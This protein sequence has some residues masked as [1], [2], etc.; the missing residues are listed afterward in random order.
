MV[1]SFQG[2]G[3]ADPTNRRRFDATLSRACGGCPDPRLRG[4]DDSIESNTALTRAARER[5]FGGGGAGFVGAV[6]GR[7]EIGRAGFAGEEQPVVDRHGKPGAIVGMAG[8][9]L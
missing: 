1:C 3:S 7:E 5:G 6:R 2:A 8:Q 9:P 4:N